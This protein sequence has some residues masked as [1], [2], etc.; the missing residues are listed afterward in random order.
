MPEFYIWAIL[1]IN[2]LD[3][4]GESNF[5]ILAGEGPNL[6]L[7]AR[8]SLFAN[9][10]TF[11]NGCMKCAYKRQR[12]RNMWQ[13]RTSITLNFSFGSHQPLWET[14]RLTQ[15]IITKLAE[16][17]LRPAISKSEIATSEGSSLPGKAS[18]SWAKHH[19]KWHSKQ[20]EPTMWLNSSSQNTTHQPIN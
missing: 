6:P 9:H 5:L 7:N 2:Q 15:G 4:I 10:I 13:I 19:I 8:S 12:K 20:R 11:D 16:E 18:T 3:E 17:S 14:P 1:L